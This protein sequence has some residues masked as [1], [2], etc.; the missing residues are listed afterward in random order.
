[1]QIENHK[2]EV[3][4]AHYEAL[5]REMDPRE[6]A[7]RLPGTQWDGTR[8]YVQ[9]MHRSY[10]IAHPA[11]SIRALVDDSAPPLSTQ[12]FILRY[13][14][15]SR[16]TAWLGQ[17]KTFREM[18][19]GEMYQKPFSGRCL[20]RAAFAFGSRLDAFRAACEKIGGSPVAHGDAGFEF[21][22]IG[23]YRM[24]ILVWEGDDEFP[25]SAQILYSDNFAASFTAE[26]RV[27][28]ADILIAAIQTNL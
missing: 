10:V 9:L 25:P 24:R 15:E 8:F 23:N 2:E 5:F 21:V 20:G 6:A 11:C 19:W 27:V 1:M 26:D 4:F 28:A 17:W 22:L 16:N 13:L 7:K 14:L 18:P 3:P 12:T